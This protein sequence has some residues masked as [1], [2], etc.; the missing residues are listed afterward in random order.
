MK[1]GTVDRKKA[2]KQWESIVKAYENVGIQ[3]Q[4]IDQVQGQP[5][6]VFATDQGIV[7]GREVVLSN[8]R[9]KER[10][11]ETKYYEKWFI[12]SGYIIK[13]IRRGEFFEGGGEVLPWNDIFFMGTGF[14]SIPE[15]VEPLSRRLG[16]KII[17]IHLINPLFYHLDTCVFPLN[18]E[19][20]FYFPKALSP[21]SIKMLENMVPNLL[22]LTHDEA[23][24]F[25]TNSVVSGRTVF[26]Q[27]GSKT[28]NKK[29]ETIGYTV[30]ELDVSEFIKAGG[31]IHCLTNILSTP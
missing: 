9:C 28:F 3:V 26:V 30:V 13:K 22:P 8:F 19:T 2:L 11:G 16:K 7:Q 18:Y 5:D 29:L 1:P 12:D 21:D 31:G 27:Q 6:M 25:S 4:I 15:S 24:N 14:R 23:F 20:V 10:R 17:P